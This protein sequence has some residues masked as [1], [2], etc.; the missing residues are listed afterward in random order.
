M[1]VHPL[2]RLRGRM[3]RMLLRQKISSRPET[4]SI[5]DSIC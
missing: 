3:K 2:R 5:A 1:Q 4:I